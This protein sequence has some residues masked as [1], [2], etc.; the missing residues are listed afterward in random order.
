MGVAHATCEK[1]L[2]EC[3]DL[4]LQITI[5]RATESEILVRGPENERIE[6]KLHN[7]EFSLMEQVLRGLTLK[8]DTLPV[9]T[10][11]E[12]K[13]IRLVTPRLTAAKLIPSVYSYT[14]NRYGFAPGTEIIRALFSARIF[15]EMSRHPGD[16]HLSTAFVGLIEHHKAPLLIER[17]I[18]PGNIEVRVKRYHIG[19][20][21]HRYKF[22]EDHGTA[23]D[24]S[25][26]RR[27]DRFEQP[28]VCFDWRHPLLNTD[29]KPLADEPLPDDYAAIWLDDIASA[30]SLARS[31]FE[32]LETRFGGAG[33]KLIDI[34]FFIDQSGSTMFG[35]ISPDC[36]RVRSKA[37]DDTDALDKDE[38]RTGGDANAVLQK[39]STLYNMLFDARLSNRGT[40]RGE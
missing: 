2:D 26:L 23:R 28:V 6:L 27:W 9:L 14:H 33:L 35:E 4:A 38:W 17:L 24:G 25:P 18:N 11:G 32:W 21:T 7:N 15:R 36:M 5:D 40:I 12:S 19:S 29:G 34:C 16:R 22:T 39:Y 8:F 31:A 37:S 20:P 13:E 30:K 3:D 10:R 1:L